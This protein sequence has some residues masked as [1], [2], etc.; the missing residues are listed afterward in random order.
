M[1]HFKQ[2][3]FSMIMNELIEHRFFF[4]ECVFFDKVIE[5]VGKNSQNI[6]ISAVIT[7]SS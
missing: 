2:G 1:K 6:E 7:F 4:A 3:F 5:L